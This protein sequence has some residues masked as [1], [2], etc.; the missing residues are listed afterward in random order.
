MLQGIIRYRPK[1]LCAVYVESRSVEILRA[2]R[3]WRSWEIEPAERF[4]VPEGESVFD[5]LQYL[6]IKPKAKK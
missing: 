4:R 3:K 1:F 2:R 6:N 5:Y